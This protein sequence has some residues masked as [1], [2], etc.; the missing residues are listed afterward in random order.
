MF[1]TVPYCTVPV[2]YGSQRG[3][4]IDSKVKFGGGV[5]TFQDEFAAKTKKS[6]KRTSNRVHHYDVIIKSAKIHSCTN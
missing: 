4:E 1:G 5:D 2:P 3:I 6:P